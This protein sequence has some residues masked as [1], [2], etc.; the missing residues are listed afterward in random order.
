MDSVNL[1]TIITIAFLGSFGHCIGMCGGIVLAYST[2]KIEPA[3]SKVSKTVAHLLYN[4]GRVLTYTLLGAIFGALGGV[5]IFSNT[6]NGVL[7]I[8]AGVA[9]VVAGLSLMG[10][11][12]FLTLI[13]HSISS[14]NFYKKSFQKI[15]HSKSNVSFFVLGMLNGLLPCGFVYF[16][17]ITAASTASPFYGAFV[18]F[19]F[20]ISTIPAM[21]SLGFLSS[22]ASATNFRNMMMSLSSVA[23]ILYGIFTI[24]NGY[25]YISNP[26]KKVVNCCSVSSGH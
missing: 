10:K 9:M 22:L 20:G 25:S 7:L 23:V 19:I 24:F 4:F 1:L 2:I 8:V 5:V 12:K 3:S 26:Y 18:M 17:A 13:E 6:A 15:L 16:F 14:A 21:F 11:I